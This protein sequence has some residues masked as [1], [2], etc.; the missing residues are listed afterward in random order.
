M[1]RRCETLKE[2]AKLQEKQIDSMT[3]LIKESMLKINIIIKMHNK[4]LCSTRMVVTLIQRYSLNFFKSQ[5]L[6]EKS[7]QGL[8]L[9][10]CNHTS[11][12]YHELL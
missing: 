7:T 12:Y 9:C 11:I 2:F 5:N 3:Y 4:N 6:V 8:H 10:F 1:I